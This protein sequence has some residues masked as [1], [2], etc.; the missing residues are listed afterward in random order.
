MRKIN[1]KILATSFMI[2]SICFSIIMSNIEVKAFDVATFS[3]GF[4]NGK[5]NLQQPTIKNNSLPGRADVSL[6]WDEYKFNVAGDEVGANYFTV[7]RPIYNHSSNKYGDWEI[8]GNY[9]SSVKV[10]NIYP[11]NEKSAGL[12]QW[13]EV[14]SG[15]NDNVDI[16]VT[17]QSQND[18][19]NNPYRYLEVN[20][21]G[22]YNYDVIVFG[23]WD[24]HNNAKLTASSGDIIQKYIDD[25]YGVIFGHDTVQTSVL[26]KG[27]N[28]LVQNNLDIFLTE[29]NRSNW[30]VSNKLGIRKQ[31]SL[32][33]YP[34]DINGMDLKISITHTVAQFPG[35]TVTGV[36]NDDIV[37][38]T[39][40]PNYYPTP[41]DGPYFN[42]NILTS[43]KGPDTR[44]RYA[45]GN[46]PAYDYIANGY[47]IKQNN[48]AFIQAG[49]SSGQTSEAEQMVL[50]NLIYSL[51]QINVETNGKDQVLDDV[52]PSVPVNVD[53]NLTFASQDYGVGYEYRIIATPIGYDLNLVN[54]DELNNA[55][56]SNVSQLN[57]EVVFSN[58]Y[59]T[60]ELK[61][62]LKGSSGYEMEADQATFRYYIDKNKVGKR[63]P[64]VEIPGQEDLQ[65]DFYTLG[66]N[67]A[68]N[69]LDH[70]SGVSQ[71]KD[72]DY[73]HVVAYD[74]ANNASNIA[75]FKLKDVLEKSDVTIVY[76]SANEILKTV[77]LL[78]VEDPSLIVGSEFSSS[79]QKNLTVDGVQYVYSNTE[80]SSQ[81][82]TI[83]SNPSNN[84]ITHNYNKL[85]SK[86]IYLVEV[87][88][89]IN[90]GA[91]IINYE[92]N[93][94]ETVETGKE[95]N[96][97]NNIPDFSSQHYVYTGWTHGR[98]VD[99]ENQSKAEVYTWA[100]DGNDIYLY[101]EKKVADV[102]VNIVRSDGL[103]FEEGIF[104]YTYLKE[105]YVG[106]TLT[107]NGN[108]IK[109][110]INIKNLNAFSNTSQGLQNY[111][112]EFYLNESG[113]FQDTITLI[114][115]TVKIIGVGI[116]Y[117]DEVSYGVENTSP[118]SIKILKENRASYMDKNLFTTTRTY[119]M[120][121]NVIEQA[122]PTIPDSNGGAN[123]KNFVNETTGQSVNI[124][125]SNNKDIQIAYYK[126]VKPNEAYSVVANYLNILDN[127]EITGKYESGTLNV[128]IQ[129]NIPVKET[130]K[131]GGILPHREVEF[132]ISHYEVIKDGVVDV[133]D[134]TLDLNEVIPSRDSKGAAETG[135]YVV[136]VY[137]RPY[138][139]VEY[140]EE[141]LDVTGEKVILTKKSNY[142]VLIDNKKKS[143]NTSLP[144][145][146]YLVETSG[147][148]FFENNKIST[149][150][151]N[152]DISVTVKYIPITY[153]L[154]VEIVG[155]LE[156]DEIVK[157]SEI[158]TN[159]NQSI[160]IFKNVPLK[161][162]VEFLI[163]NFEN[164][165]Y[166]FDGVTMI[167]GS[168]DDI[169][170][171]DEGR[172]LIFRPTD[173]N[174][175]NGT[176]YE[177][178][179][180]Y[181]KISE[182]KG[183]AKIYRFNQEPRKE[184]IMGSAY[185]GDT[186][187]VS[188]PEVDD[189]EL[190]N[191]YL[192]GKEYFNVETGV[193]YNILV[194]KP[195]H[196]LELR[197]HEI[198]YNFEAVSATIGGSI[199]GN[200]SFY[201]NEKV[202]VQALP[203]DGYKLERLIVNQG[204]VELIEEEGTVWTYYFIMPKEN[205]RIEAYFTTDNDTSEDIV[206]NPFIPE[207]DEEDEEDYYEDTTNIDE[208]DN[209]DEVVEPEVPKKPIN[210]TSD[211]IMDLVNDPYY[212][213]IR[214][215][216]PYI[217]GYPS[218]NMEPS[219]NI[220]R[221][222]VMTVIYNLY[223]NGY[224][225]DKLSLEKFSDVDKEKWYSNAIGFAIDFN[226]VL[227]YED[228]TFK[229]DNSITRAELAVIIAKFV[230]LAD[231]NVDELYFSDVGNNWA[232]ESIEKLYRKGIVSGYGGNMF[233][234]SGTANRAE[235]VT[236]VNRLIGRG[237]TYYKNKTFPDVPQNHWAYDNIMNA[238]NGSIIDMELDN[239]M[240]IKINN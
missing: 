211:D 205:V 27:F 201:G 43:A 48:V 12:K 83:E 192:D 161:V 178:N 146:E 207:E 126:G 7:R 217:N 115:R 99:V 218:G 61:A 96:I 190:T 73:L 33:T 174:I 94:I 24:S 93:R 119:E 162:P 209:K 108:D 46:N 40:E 85:V 225:S 69:Y 39:L 50:A 140:I 41:G 219:S 181:R 54:K 80:P 240:L 64:S 88:P 102:K 75:D 171:E 234:P 38:V 32:T 29:R 86:N 111:S 11:N 238:S 141:L 147:N 59:V 180:N 164:S 76:K 87:R 215:Y 6:N 122:P 92:I 68:F 118:S 195:M 66:Y 236:L 131:I 130:L 89:G 109:S 152:Y 124:D 145:D 110:M 23:F 60:T 160:Y 189:L 184:N 138:A 78:G 10:L 98:G 231:I 36:P 57:D 154:K 114:P 18:F 185:I 191:A 74:R 95:I 193:S 226:V 53:G 206:I 214:K 183:V 221:A 133:Y 143:L 84:I 137:Y 233:N 134:A 113:T 79:A 103:A 224:I 107:I 158:N 202:Y 117:N 237:D 45:L 149:L 52:E 156:N 203:D 77:T 63:T 26:E 208:V 204:N 127:N 132:E 101:Y 235:F 97:E 112:S 22:T 220:T 239:S 150:I 198:K 56:S 31:G 72:N 104:E 5:L 3:I 135:D 8:R 177:L 100:D 157:D 159:E 187:S 106:E 155:R 153:N 19:N 223:G 51:A 227:G 200:G 128:A 14:Q 210:P 91:D 1:L 90:G 30:Y 42:Y 82:I 55:L 166:Y 37:Y 148:A 230:D 165:N 194:D 47:L 28:N 179:L 176:T 216:K 213:I 116:D 186:V 58:S 121:L 175:I 170:Y 199:D 168:E 120:D 34:F 65:D 13:M 173:D 35:D 163:P 229:P 49:H 167:H 20:E 62:Q 44:V 21:N 136:N 17:S 182:L 70:F 129:P 169:R 142:N 151:N 139:N 81:F 105:G 71:I 228:G 15:V 9:G 196:L 2:M 4:T 172:R 188:V 232:T 144:T 67:E 123:W 16:Q 222:E 125:F 212:S 197:Y 25:G